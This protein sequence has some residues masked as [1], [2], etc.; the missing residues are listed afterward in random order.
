[1]VVVAV[2]VLEVLEQAQALPLPQALLT[3]LLSVLVV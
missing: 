1:M 2:E 3:Q